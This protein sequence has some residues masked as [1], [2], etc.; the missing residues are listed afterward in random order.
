M[1]NTVKEIQ[2]EHLDEVVEIFFEELKIS[3]LSLFGKEFIKKMFILLLKENLGFVSLSDESNKVNG[4]IIMVKQDISLFKCITFRSILNFITKILTN[5]SILKAFLISFFKLYLLRNSLK[6]DT[7]SSVEL[8]HFAV[9]DSFKGKGIGT[10]LIKRLEK[11]AKQESYS[12]VFTST[13]NLRLVEF[14]KIKKNAKILHIVDV[15]TY[16]SH[17]II[18][19]IE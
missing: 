6:D 2:N 16:K 14:Y 7:K 19:D 11:Q 1:N 13:H 9:K 15:G 12:K 8:S 3:I 5:Y 18:W 4:F 10:N 17:N